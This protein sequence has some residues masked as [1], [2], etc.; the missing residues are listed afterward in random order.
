MQRCTK[1]SC[2]SAGCNF[3][4]ADVNTAT[5]KATD[6]EQHLSGGISTEDA[7]EQSH[8]DLYNAMHRSHTLEQST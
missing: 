6:E 1:Q 2:T 8:C 4:S 7:N 5:R 3:L